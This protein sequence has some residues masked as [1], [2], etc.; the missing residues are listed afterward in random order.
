MIRRNASILIVLLAMVLLQA[1]TYQPSEPFFYN[2]ETRHVMSGVFFM[3]LFHDRPTHLRQY[4][5]D[6]YLKYPA[7]GILVWPPLFYGLEGVAMAVFG[8]SVVVARVLLGLFGL[9]AGLYLFVLSRRVVG[10]NRAAMSVLAFGTTPLIFKYS[11]F[12]MLEIP[13]LALALGATY[14]F[15]VYLEQETKRDLYLWGFLCAAAALTR[16]DVIYLLVLFPVLLTVQKKWGI[17]KRR[18]VV[19]TVI[20]ALLLIAP[21]YAVTAANVGWLHGKEVTQ[22]MDPSDPPMLSLSRLFFYPATL[23][24][25]LSWFFVGAAVFGLAVAIWRRDRS[26]LVFTAIIVAVYVTFTPI[27]EMRERHVIYWAPALAFFAA[28]GVYHASRFWRD[29]I[30]AGILAGAVFGGAFA[31]AV[32][33]VRTFLTGYA[34]A[35]RYVEAN[36]TSPPLCLFIGSLNGNFVYQMRRADSARRIWTLRGEKLADTLAPASN[37]ATRPDADQMLAAI[38][39]YSPTYILVERASDPARSAGSEWLAKLVQ[40]HEERFR[41]ER[42]FPIVT[43]SPQYAYGMILVYRNL[44]PNPSAAQS[45]E[46]HIRMLRQNVQGRI[47]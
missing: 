21:V 16:F 20:G 32:P 13:M 2:D 17:L 35:A 11:H 40:G 19:L 24:Y 43:N 31:Q 23:P 9:L 7:L 25:N 46:L 47:P 18:E 22:T 30:T 4:A 10:P 39:R 45:V 26:C 44:V 41:L 6:Y 12:V 1:I 36:T 37:E 15:V 8:S 29:G 38:Y 5:I 28:E 3:D 33:S 14:H 27:A 42:S 34:D